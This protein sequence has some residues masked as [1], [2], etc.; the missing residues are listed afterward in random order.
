MPEPLGDLQV[1]YWRNS[2]H[3][4]FL[5]YGAEAWRVCGNRR[6]GAICDGNTP[7]EAM[8]RAI[9]AAKKFIEEFCS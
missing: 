3:K 4:D 5:P 8:Q 7:E 2:P 9:A 6:E 1:R